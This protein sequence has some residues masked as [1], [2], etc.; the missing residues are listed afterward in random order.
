MNGSAQAIKATL[1]QR[2]CAVARQHT[3]AEQAT[4]SQ[5]ICAR[6]REQP[7]WQRARRIAAFWPMPG[8]PDLRPIYRE[9]LAE[10]KELALPRF[11]PDLHRYIICRIEDDVLDVCRGHFGITEPLASC[12]PVELKK[13]D[14]WL[15]PGVGFALDGGRLGRGKGYYDQMLSEAQGFKCGVAFEWQ[16]TAEVPAESHD[17]ILDCILTPARW[18]EVASVRRL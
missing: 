15:V 11:L 18:A 12:Q 7:V 2:L 14:F 4:A 13:L 3:P 17:I 10:R 6:L 1:R 9:A 16:L 8:E 5:A